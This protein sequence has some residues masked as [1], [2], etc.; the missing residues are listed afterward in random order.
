MRLIR[1]GGGSSAREAVAKAS[2]A[3]MNAMKP[4]RPFLIALAL[5]WVAASTAAFIYSQQQNISRTLLY[6][7]L[8]AFLVEIAF[9]LMPGFDSM[10]KAFDQ[11]GSKSVRAVLLVA[12]AATPYLMESLRLGTFQF[13]AF[14]IL[15][16][17][18]AVSAFWY[19]IFKPSLLADLTFLAFLA[20]VYLSK[21][22]P[23]IYVRPA[24]HLQIEILGRLMWIRLGVMA[25]LSLRRIDKVRFG[26]I[27]NGKEWRVGVEQF[28]FFMPVG[29][30]LAYL[31]KFARFHPLPM[32]WWKLALLAPAIFVGVLW[33]VALSEEFF[34]RGFLQPRLAKLLHGEIPGL[35]AASALFG[36]LHLPFRAFPNWRFAIIAGITGLFYGI[37]FMRT[38]SV[39]ASM[40]T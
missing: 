10:R 31:L 19:A 27:P 15:L 23:Q 30:L 7:L 22:F 17:L 24:P 25:L 26:F 9:Y 1:P 12:A 38:G 37:A 21:A 20:A 33:V 2:D 6:A 36:A 8:P 3:T 5:V 18:A 14:L 32:V 4:M 40:V 16:T 35:I 29:A 11:L 39:R 34:F 13:T 28:L